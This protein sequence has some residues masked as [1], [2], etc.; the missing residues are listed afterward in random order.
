MSGPDERDHRPLGFLVASGAG[1]TAM[2]GADRLHAL[3]ER[4]GDRVEIIAGGSVSAENVVDLVARTGVRA[5][6]GR[7]FRGVPQRLR[8]VHHS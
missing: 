5:V 3:V 2:E 8:P 7:A 1:K 6:H 4:A